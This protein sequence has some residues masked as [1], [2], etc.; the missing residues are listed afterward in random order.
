M[1]ID[2]LSPNKTNE[3]SIVNSSVTFYE[4]GLATVPPKGL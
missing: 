3:S 2:I 4:H 1:R